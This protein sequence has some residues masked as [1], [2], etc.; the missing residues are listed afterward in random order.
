M[1][2]FILKRIAGM[3][4]VLLVILLLTFTMIRVAPGGPFDRDRK[5]PPAIEKNIR[6]RFNL[7]LP[8]W[9]QFAL[10][11][12]DVVLHFDLGPSTK[13][14]NRTVNEIIAQTLP[15]SMTVGGIAFCLASLSGIALGSLAA[16]RR[17]TAVDYAS[18]MASMTA[19][20]VPVFVLA[21]ICLLIFGLKLGWVPIAGWGSWQNVVLPAILLSLPYMA[22]VARLMRNSLIEVLQQDFVRTALAK[23]VSRHRA[24]VHHAFKLALLPVI[25]FMGPMA[26]EVLTGGIVVEKIFNLPG[27]GPFFVSAVFD[28]DA[29]V[30]AGITLVF[31]VMLLFFNLVVDVVYHYLDPRIRIHT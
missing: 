7:D 12:K 10:W 28:R 6:A 8:V 15:V 20:C 1:T 18:M 19:I 29:F 30:V 27:M 16:V 22:Y 5:L 21:P 23:G 31:S 13:Y 2:T 17:N 24:V 3:A 4:P 26:A 14:R 11:M 9:E 25:S